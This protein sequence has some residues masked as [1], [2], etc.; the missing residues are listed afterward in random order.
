M[1]RTTCIQ[2]VM[3]AQFTIYKVIHWSTE[4]LNIIYLN[5]SS[6]IPT[7]VDD[8]KETNSSVK[9]RA[10]SSSWQHDICNAISWFSLYKVGSYF[11]LLMRMKTD[12][13]EINL[14]LRCHPYPCPAYRYH[15]IMLSLCLLTSLSA[16]KALCDNNVNAPICHSLIKN[17]ESLTTK[18]HIVLLKHKL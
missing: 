17:K 12:G 18:Q 5:Y 10:S 2:R 11:N 7:I 6:P 4:V 1:A 13:G 16:I 14:L 15:D 8:G 9:C 3:L